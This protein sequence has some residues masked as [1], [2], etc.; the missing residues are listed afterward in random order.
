MAGRSGPQA[1]RLAVVE[2]IATERRGEQGPLEGDP[3]EEHAQ[4]ARAWDHTRSGGTV[5]GDI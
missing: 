1:R 3:H 2:D 5:T 4:A